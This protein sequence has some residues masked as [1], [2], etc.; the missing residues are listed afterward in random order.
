MQKI[1]FMYKVA[2]CATIFVATI[3]VIRHDNMSD[4]RILWLITLPSYTTYVDTAGALQYE[5]I[6]MGTQLS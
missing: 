4:L 5:C 3:F 2:F 1:H 6:M